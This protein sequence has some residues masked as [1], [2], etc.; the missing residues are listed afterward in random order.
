MLLVVNCLSAYHTKMAPVRA[1]FFRKYVDRCPKPGSSV[2]TRRPDS[3]RLLGGRYKIPALASAGGSPDGA[4]IA[5]D[6]GL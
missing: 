4:A 6:G 5:R 1:T 3:P 2:E